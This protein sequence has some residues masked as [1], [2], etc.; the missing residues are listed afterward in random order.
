MK[1]KTKLSCENKR[2][3]ISK[4]I[5]FQSI[6]YWWANKPNIYLKHVQLETSVGKKEIPT[7]VF[8]GHE[9]RTSKKKKPKQIKKTKT[10]PPPI[11]NSKIPWK[12]P[13]WPGHVPKRYKSTSLSRGWQL[14]LRGGQT[15]LPSAATFPA[16]HQWREILSKNQ[17]TF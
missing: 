14:F 3:T 4:N 9:K 11:N 13:H 7:K 17:G 6:I 16:P 15:P 10:K 12:W 5:G 8:L 2:K 1:K